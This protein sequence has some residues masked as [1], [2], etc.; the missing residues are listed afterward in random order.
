MS[1]HPILAVLAEA[2]FIL[3]G[4]LRSGNTEAARGV[5]P[6]LQE[7]LVLLPE[8]MWIRCVRVDSGFFEEAILSFLEERKLPYLVVARMTSTLQRRCAG[9]KDWTVLDDR[10]AVGEFT[11]QLFGWSKARRLVVL[12]ERVREGQD[13]V[14]QRL[15]DVPGYTS[16]CG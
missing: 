12:R 8:G 16:G 14:G 3:H 1:H 2:P 9:L 7:A 11:V 10:Y 15:R 6:F 13:A 5:V 4:W